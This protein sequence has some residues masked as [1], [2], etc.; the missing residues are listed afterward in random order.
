MLYNDIR[1]IN[2]TSR[3]F[4]FPSLCLSYLWCVC[5]SVCLNSYDS[6]IQTIL[7][8]GLKIGQ[9]TKSQAKAEQIRTGEKGINTIFL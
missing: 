3:V 9:A 4:T 5:A 6:V 1:D 7:E 8:R 2:I